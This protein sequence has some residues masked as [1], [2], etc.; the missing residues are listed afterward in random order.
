MSCQAGSRHGRDNIHALV[1]Q[2][3]WGLRLCHLKLLVSNIKPRYSYSKLS[4][5]EHSSPCAPNPTSA[6]AN[7]FPLGFHPILVF[8]S[9][10]N[11]PCSFQATSAPNHK[12]FAP[13][14]LEDMFPTQRGRQSQ[15][16]Q[17]CWGMAATYLSKMEPTPALWALLRCTCRPVASRI[18]SCTDTERW[19]KEAM[20]SSFQP[21][22]TG[23][24]HTSGSPAKKQFHAEQQSWFLPAGFGLNS[25][26]SWHPRY[27]STPCKR[28]EMPWKYLENALK[29]MV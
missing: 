21:A 5:Q 23:G 2:A 29:P 3:S 25:G 15:P 4:R 8:L 20:S 1:T 14:P 9:H 11:I 13:V 7:P 6:S 28:W 12:G 22:S 27:Q 16:G 17:P 18:P 10:S 24:Q 26:E 19:E